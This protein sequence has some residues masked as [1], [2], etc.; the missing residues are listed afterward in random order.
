MVTIPEY[1]DPTLRAMY[2]AIE[3]AQKP[4]KRDYLG[5][6]L[7]GND[8]PRQIWYEHNGFPKPAFEAE[9]LMNFED[10]HRTE[11]LTAQRLR[12]VPGVELV[13]HN[14][15]GE[16]IG[17]SALGGKFRG[18]CDGRIIG[19]IQAPK[20][21][22]IW[23]HK[24]PGQKKFDEFVKAKQ[25]YGEKN[26][27][28]NWNENYFVQ[29]Q[30]YMHFLQCDRHYLTVGLAGGRKYQSARTEYQ[31]EIAARYIERAEKIINATQPPPRIND[32]PDF[33]I[34]RFCAFK[35]TCHG[36]RT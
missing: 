9:T 14:D 31:P 5:A 17:F 28:K 19:L 8:C 36:Q 24:A 11:A 29:A 15:K 4:Q 23:E 26:A 33:F 27:L 18:H 20:A 1:G 21:P 22:H 3:Q 16:Q 13:T 10:G 12:M 34:C 30:L 6:S 25:T 35:D 2:A 7:I 32:K